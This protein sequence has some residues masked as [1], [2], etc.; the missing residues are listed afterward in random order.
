M[1]NG[2]TPGSGTFTNLNIESGTSAF[3]TPTN[4]GDLP[5]SD[6]VR[7]DMTHTLYAATDFG[8]LSGKNDGTG[9]WFVTDL[10]RYEVMHLA[11]EPSARDA[12]CTSGNN[13]KRVIY[14]ATH[15]QGIWKM[16]LKG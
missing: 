9:G 10:P 6:I 5:V 2:T 15:S 4:D 14:A 11:I 12:T 16:N 1:E 13:C 8:V 7:D 3:P